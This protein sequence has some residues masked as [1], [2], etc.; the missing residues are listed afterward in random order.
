MTEND[1]YTGELARVTCE[2][3]PLRF[4][5]EEQI[6]DELQDG[7][8]PFEFSD[9]IK[10]ELG[11]ALDSFCQFAEVI[12]EVNKVLD[13]IR[14]SDL[15]EE[16][17]DFVVRGMIRSLGLTTIRATPLVD[18][19]ED[20]ESPI[21]Q[22]LRLCT[23][24]RLSNSC[25]LVGKDQSKELPINIDANF[26]ASTLETLARHGSNEE[27]RTM[28]NTI[29]AA[30]EH[31]KVPTLSDEMN[32]IDFMNYAKEDPRDFLFEVVKFLYLLKKSE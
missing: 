14:D 15:V 5:R 32:L 17:S 22:T 26:G 29:V 8:T 7:V 30:L 4:L 20:I 27:I 25:E 13:F 31:F 1:T 23:D 6:I 2:S 11:E 19:L 24:Q 10:N 28:A 9:A 3:C 18:T 21:G 16:A 12:P